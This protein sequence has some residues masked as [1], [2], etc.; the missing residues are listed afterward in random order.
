MT[1]PSHPD[2]VTDSINWEKYRLSYEGGRDFVEKYLKQYTSREDS[3]DFTLRKSITYCP[4]HAKAAI[5]EIKNSIFERMSDVLR[6][7]G[8]QSYQEAINGVEGG[9]DFTGRNMTSFVGAEVLPELLVM[10]RVG[11]FVDKA[12]VKEVRTK[13]EDKG[14]RPYL[15]VYK[16]EDILSWAYNS[17]NELV[18]VLLRSN[19]TVIDPIT[20]LAT[21]VEE[22]LRLL[23]LVDGV[24]T[25]TM[26]DKDGKLGEATVLKLKQIPFVMFEMTE[27]LMCDIADYQIALLNLESSDLAYLLKSNFPFYTEQTNQLSD[28]ANLARQG[29]VTLDADGKP[30]VAVAD[31]AQSVSIGATTG[32]RY[33]KG[34][35]RPGFIHPSPEP[36]EVSMAKQTDMKSAIRQL[37]Q[38]ALSN[39]APQRASGES[40]QM[41]QQGLEAGLA[42]I[43]LVLETGENKIAKIWAEYEGEDPA[44]VAYPDQYSLL[45]DADR[46]TLAKELA[47]HLPKVPS[48]TAQKAIAKKIAFLIIGRGITLKQEQDII[49]EIDDAEIIAIDPEVLRLDIEAGLVGL[50][51]ASSARLYPKG[52]VAIAKKEHIARLAAIAIAQ[53]PG[54]GAGSDA[55]R[56]IP[57]GAQDKSGKEEK[58]D[59]QDS[60]KQELGKGKAVR[61]KE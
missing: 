42:Y 50:E 53:A 47:T 39:L 52:Q 61:G 40:K 54:G 57:T 3:A 30:I 51:L 20:G 4:A 44:L 21:G 24:V 34:T 14:I 26:M 38:L 37:V 16:A 12:P 19:E 43:G 56:G 18:S 33:P 46:L 41:D 8:P 27:S 7:G 2:Y 6:I 36:M 29:Q 25:V 35:E 23:R 31:G 60:D 11:V 45:S 17:K 55:A 28:M 58:D 22:K 48:L 9:V 32:R 5:M 1:I 15:Y 13:A 49:K 59:S 10:R